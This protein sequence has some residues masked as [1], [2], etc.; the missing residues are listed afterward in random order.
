V[1]RG[2]P[3]HSRTS[4]LCESYEWQPWSGYVSVTSYTT[5]PEMEYH[6]VRHSAGLMDVSPLKKY[7]IEG[8]DAGRLVQKAVTRDT[9]KLRPGQIVYTCWCDEEGKTVDDGT[10]W[11]LGDD[12]YRMTAAT[13]NLKWLQDVGAGLD[14]TV[15]D[16]SDELAVA[17]LQ[18]PLSR[19]ILNDATGGA[20][21]KLKWF[22]FTPAKLDGVPVT[23]SRTGF[24][25][26]LGYEVWVDPPN[27]EGVWDSVMRH[28]EAYDA[29]AVGMHA[30]E[31]TRIEAGFILA[32]HD[33][34][35]SRDAIIES[36]KFSPFELSLD[37][38][39]NLGKG[40]FVGRSAL[41]EEAARGPR[42]RFV[43]LEVDWAAAER[44][45]R[46]FGLPPMPPHEP[47][48]EYVPIYSGSRQIGRGTSGVW[49]PIL[50][51]FIAMGFVDAGHSALGTR[52]QIE[53]TIEG[54]H[55]L[56]PAR[57]VPRPFF[58][59]ERKRA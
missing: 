30:L 51:K 15:E 34:T 19:A 33:Y 29:V 59:P 27:A 54:E 13:P 14:A 31:V 21:E 38:T 43:G 44:L 16:V 8:P 25:G 50:K 52:V 4:K 48:E 47:W 18:G 9:S 10:L 7:R 36:Q 24:T 40:P 5:V 22:R 55:R 11:N 6:A 42:R 56:A 26:D 28:G 57:V 58:D 45:Y 23:I 41:V 49:S 35:P 37:W 39:V 17:A 3:F 1:R 46:S 12:T 53:L 20:I 32:E 2:T